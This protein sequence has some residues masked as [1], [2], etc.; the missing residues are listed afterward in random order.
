MIMYYVT[1]NWT[2]DTAIKM[3]QFIG[4]FGNEDDAQDYA[5]NENAKLSMRGVP[6]W[7]ASFHVTA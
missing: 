5:N 4:P 6:S 7:V 2:D 1:L 3:P